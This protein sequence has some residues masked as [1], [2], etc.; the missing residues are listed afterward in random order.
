MWRAMILLSQHHCNSAER[1][2]KPAK[3]SA[4]DNEYRQQNG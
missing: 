2:E 3:K 4:K 1:N